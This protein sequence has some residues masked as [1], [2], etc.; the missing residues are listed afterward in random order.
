MKFIS[1]LNIA[2]C[3]LLIL[4]PQLFGFAQGPDV[5]AQGATVQTEQAQK[6]LEA[7]PLPTEVTASEV[8]PTPPTE[9]PL[10]SISPAEPTA[11][12]PA[13]STVSTPEVE[14]KETI[15][16]PI[17]TPSE[18]MPL[19]TLQTQAMPLDQISPVSIQSGE[20]QKEQTPAQ[21]G[22]SMEPNIGIAKE[23]R[24]KVGQ[25]LNGLLA[26]EFALYVKILNYHW[27]LKSVQFND[28]HAFFKNLYE[29]QFEVIDDVAE[30]AQTIGTVA[31][32]TLAEFSKHTQIKETPGTVPN[33]QT[34]LKNLLADYET[35]IQKIRIDA[36]KALEYK[37][38][39]TNNFLV[40]LME[41]Q[42]KIA[43]MIRSSIK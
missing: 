23:N 37:D 32:G 13:E 18:Q 36:D 17:T 7:V 3:A 5:R 25:M 40:D 6:E 9:Q 11:T 10:P 16:A 4:I 43:W 30:R 39:G 24:E 35:I 20:V 15:S 41:K 1:Y 33:D 31:F 22:F 21:E 34:M 12:I 8:F 27:N 19:S 29:K 38:A 14:I 28:L 2:I 26:D 42:E